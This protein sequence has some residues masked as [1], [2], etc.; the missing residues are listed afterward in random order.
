M[1]WTLDR[2]PISMR[3]LPP[4]V[5][6]KAVEMA[7]ALLRDGMDEGQAIRIATAKARA[8]ALQQERQLQF[9]DGL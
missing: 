3:K 2:P 1:P 7:N 5:Q 9:N 6:R 8:W 4:S